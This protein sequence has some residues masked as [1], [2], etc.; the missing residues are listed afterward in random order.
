MVLEIY[1]QELGAV[2]LGGA[3]KLVVKELMEDQLLVMMGLL[4]ASLRI[5]KD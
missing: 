1:Q 3:K 4:F 5:V 2:I